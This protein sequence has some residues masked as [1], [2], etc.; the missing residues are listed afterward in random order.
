MVN[1]NLPSSPLGLDKTFVMRLHR[2]DWMFKCT[3]SQ[4]RGSPLEI[5]DISADNYKSTHKIISFTDKN[6]VIIHKLMMNLRSTFWKLQF[7]SCP[8]SW[9]FAG[10]ILMVSSDYASINL[11][12]CASW[13]TADDHQ[14]D[15]LWTLRTMK[16]IPATGLKEKSDRQWSSGRWNFRQEGEN[17]V[18]SAIL[19]VT[20]L[21]GCSSTGREPEI[22]WWWSSMLTPIVLLCTAL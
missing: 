10:I 3:C 9:A 16:R 20:G 13:L 18:P 21:R 17:L 2:S 22:W 14:V 11:H 6:A 7:I 12:C 19:R 1:S 5:I 8:Y 15:E 4:G